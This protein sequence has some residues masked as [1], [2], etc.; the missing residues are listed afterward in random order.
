MLANAR[1]LVAEGK[2]TVTIDGRKQKTRRDMPPGSESISNP[3]ENGGVGHCLASVRVYHSIKAGD[4][5]LIVR[6]TKL[7]EKKVKG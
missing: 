2:E 6:W 1:I 3:T 4:G 5:G 7:H